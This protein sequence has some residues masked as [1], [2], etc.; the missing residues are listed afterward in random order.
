VRAFVAGG[1]G[2]DGSGILGER[3]IEC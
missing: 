2:A 3:P 1:S